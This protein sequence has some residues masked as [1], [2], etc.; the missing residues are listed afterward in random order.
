MKIS[1][2]CLKIFLIF[3]L[4]LKES[5]SKLNQSE[6]KLKI[7]TNSQEIKNQPR[8]IAE[9]NKNIID[10]AITITENKK[11][12]KSQLKSVIL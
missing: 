10:T 9:T 2:I 1:E 4:I 12:L 7:S 3:L 6:V 8:D 11:N 5:T